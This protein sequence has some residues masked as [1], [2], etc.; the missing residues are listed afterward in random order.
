MNRFPNEREE[1][2]RSSPNSLI[3]NERV[4]GL[5]LN[6]FLTKLT[7]YKLISVDL[8]ILILRPQNID[9][10]QILHHY[11]PKKN[12]RYETYHIVAV[13]TPKC[14]I[15]HNIDIAATI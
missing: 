7:Q 11:L 6:N 13:S 4:I 3:Y 8:F 1:F 15:G 14:N 5:G 2:G 9:S 12:I 10:N